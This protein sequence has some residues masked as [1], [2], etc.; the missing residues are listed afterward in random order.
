MP[1]Q[2]GEMSREQQNSR[3]VEYPQELGKV[4]RRDIVKRK[5]VGIGGTLW[6]LARW[7]RCTELFTEP[8]RFTLEEVAMYTVDV[9]FDLP[10]WSARATAKQL[11]RGADDTDQEMNV[12]TVEVV[13]RVPL[14]LLYG[15][16]GSEIVAVGHDG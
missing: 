8:C 12:A 9:V 16:L 2:R 7:C 3:V 11:P 5:R 10:S 1:R 13:L 15:R 4:V 6:G 14:D